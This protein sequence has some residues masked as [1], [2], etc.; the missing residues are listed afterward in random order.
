MSCD[1][2]KDIHVAQQTGLSGKACEC[3]CHGF[4]ITEPIWCSS[5]D[6]TTATYN[7]AC[8]SDGC[9]NLNLNNP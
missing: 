5:S 3:S 4:S 8:T 6:C 1:R 7:F 9:A 2:C